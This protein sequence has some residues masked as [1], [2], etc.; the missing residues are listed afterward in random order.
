M[1][2]ESIATSGSEQKSDLSRH[3]SEQSSQVAKARKLANNTTKVLPLEIAL[4]QRCSI[5]SFLLDT[6]GFAGAIDS[7]ILLYGHQKK[8]PV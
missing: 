8:R 3:F 4:Q 1:L 7:Y 5:Q 2:S 6:F